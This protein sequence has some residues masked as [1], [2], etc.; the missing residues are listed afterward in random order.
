MKRLFYSTVAVLAFLLVGFS[1]ISC[2]SDDLNSNETVE[3]N[4]LRI[5]T[6]N[7]LIELYDEIIREEDLNLQKQVISTFDFETQAALFQMKFNNFLSANQ[8]NVEQ[9]AF[10]NYLVSLSTA[11]IFEEAR[12]SPES[13]VELSNDIQLN[14]VTLFGENEGWYLVNRFENINQTI[15]KIALNHNVSNSTL[16][17]FLSDNTPYCECQTWAGCKRL[18]GVGITIC[19]GAGIQLNWEYGKCNNGGCTRAQWNLGVFTILSND[20]GLCS[21]D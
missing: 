13:F 11:E 6:Q 16:R 7:E 9:I 21:Y 1:S 8:L 12:I 18:T 19:G 5:L 2:S 15:D 4:N 3:Q 10:V 14:A 17:R 20:T